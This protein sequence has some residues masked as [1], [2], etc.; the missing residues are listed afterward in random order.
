V[1]AGQELLYGLVPA[2]RERL[3]WG[4]SY[5]DAYSISTRVTSGKRSRK[6]QAELYA[7]FKA[8]KGN[9][10]VRHGS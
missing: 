8:G 4:L 2:F 7:A 9:P 6:R 3:E 1:V 5:L 10:A